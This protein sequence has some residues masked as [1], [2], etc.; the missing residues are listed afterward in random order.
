ML[1]HPASAYTIATG[2]SESCHERMTVDAYFTLFEGIEQPE[3]VPDWLP[4]EFVPL[5]IPIPDSEVWRKVSD[6]VL[7]GIG[8]MGT[9]DI[10]DWQRVVVTSLA[11]GV[12]HPDT[13]GHSV[14][15]L[16]T[17]RDAHTNPDGQYVHFL[18]SSTDDHDEG[19]ALAIIQ[20]RQTLRDN[21]QTGLAYL[22]FPTERQLITTTVYAD[23]YGRIQVDVWAPAFY[24]GVALHTL[25]DSFSHTVRS[26]DLTTIRHVM[27][28]IDAVTTG[29][30]PGRDGLAHSDAMDDCMGDASEIAAVAL[31]AT[32]EFFI[33]AFDARAADSL[34]SVDAFMDRWFAYEPGCNA[35]N[36]F[37]DSK[38]ASLAQK[39]ATEPFI[40]D[41]FACAQVSPHQPARDP[42]TVV[43]VGMFAWLGLRR[44]NMH[45]QASRGGV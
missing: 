8:P 25:Q 19:N 3:Q 44:R 7:S 1:P 34:D 5:D 45:R 38:W 16:D 13:E 32:E 14:T 28:F 27:N 2:F 4:E 43:V 35:D 12:R 10:A 37:C 26:D 21:I 22:D 29:H 23:F 17:L 42:L 20:S 33:A 24:L 31:M 18:R 41:I 15:N 6:S 36:N 39:D 30:R 11:L 40:A 9:S